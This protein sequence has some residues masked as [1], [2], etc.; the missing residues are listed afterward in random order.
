VFQIIPTWREIAWRNAERLVTAGTD[1]ERAR[2][3]ADIEVYAASQAET[4]RAANA[5][6]PGQ[7]SAQRDAYRT[8]HHG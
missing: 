7:T 3:A 4:I 8:L 1:A 2:V 5:Y 6:L